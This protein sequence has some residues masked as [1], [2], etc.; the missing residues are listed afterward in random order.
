MSGESKGMGIWDITLFSI[1]A[2]LVIDT[3]TAS[4]SM[5]ASSIGWWVIMFFVFVV[6]YILITSEL[7]TTYPGEGGIYDWV[8]RAFGMRWAIRTTWFYWVNVALWMPAVYI[9]FAGMFAELFAPDLSLW[10]QIA[11]AIVLTW[12]TVWICNISVDVGK[13]IPNLAAAAKMIILVVLGVG[14][15][16]YATNNGVANE[17]SLSAMAPS[18]DTGLAFLPAIVF[19]LLGFE[20]VATMGKEIRNP[21]KDMP[22]AMFLASGIVCLLYIVGTIGILVAIPADEIGLV[23]GLVETFR[24][25]LAE[26]PG[27]EFLVILLGIVALFT[28]VGNMVTWSMGASRAALEAA[29]EGELPAYFAKEHPV[30]K[31]PIGANMLLGLISTAV[32]ILYGFTAGGSD[33]LFWTVFAFSSCVFLLPYL[34][35]FPAFAKLRKMDPTRERPFK[36]KGNSFWVALITW[37][38]FLIVFQAVFFFILPEIVSGEIDWMY[39]GPVLGGILLT[40]IIGEWILAGAIKRIETEKSAL[41]NQAGHPAE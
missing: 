24:L 35:M 22:K 28:F 6:P 34:L 5:G 17:I 39:T 41:G 11:M 32:V 37:V 25:F 18:W 9:L 30:H 26:L 2:V 21:Q 27:S 31:T 15:F 1:C 12:I 10:M 3:L 33:E 13:W 8:K 4:A 29:H 14:G 38:P 7:G 23:A 36:V 40:I 19:N 20:L 16:L